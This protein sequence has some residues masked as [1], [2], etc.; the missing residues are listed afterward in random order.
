MSWQAPV[1]GSRPVAVLGGGV[2][3]RRIACSFVAA[4]YNANIRD[5]SAEARRDALSF[6]DSHK[7][8]FAT[9]AKPSTPGLFGSYT[10]YEDIE[11]AVRDAWL[12]VEAVPEKLELKIDT[13][14]LL[15]KFAPHDCILGSNSSSYRSSLMLDKVSAERKKMICNIH[16]TMPMDICTVELMTD[17]ETEEAIFPFLTIILERC[18]MFPAT[19]RKESTG[20]IFNRLWAAVKRETMTILAEGVSDP[21]QIDMLWGKM[22]KAKVTPCALMDQVGLDT[23]AFIEDNYIRERKLDGQLTVDWLRENYISQGKLG[24]KSAKGGLISPTS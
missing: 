16:Y 1:I 20:F 10:A 13:F 2:L 12:V 22:F 8:E 24:K 21:E 15:D 6:I 7:Q 17:G 3:G 9:L 11:S 5:P 14:E 18:G 4:G 23:V 19:A